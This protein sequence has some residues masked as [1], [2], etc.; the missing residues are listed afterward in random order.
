MT[1]RIRETGETLTVKFGEGPGRPRLR[2]VEFA[3]GTGWFY[4]AYG[5]IFFLAGTS[6]RDVLTVR[7]RF[8]TAVYGEGGNDLVTGSPL[9]DL[10]VGGRGNDTLQGE[11]GDDAL[12]GE[13]GDDRLIGGPGRDVLEGGEGNDEVFGGTG[14]D[15]LFGG[16]GDD[17]LNGGQGND[18]LQGGAGDDRLDGGPGDDAYLYFAGVGQDIIDNTGGGND[19]LAF[20]DMTPEGLWLA[21]NGRDL[22]VGVVGSPDKITVSGWFGSGRR[23]DAVKAGRMTLA[24]G[25]VPGL[26]EALAPVGPPAGPG[27]TW[28]EEQLTALSRLL[29]SFWKRG[30]EAPE[31]NP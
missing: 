1:I 18:R 13:T 29:P 27:M 20:F 7:P 5:G 24:E 22:T 3:D 2:K 26:L 23:I 14:D 17:L 8:Y 16:N 21:R 30:A 10:I 28:T 9:G 6:G 31:G 11:A 12:D 4:R 19:T 15:L 25:D